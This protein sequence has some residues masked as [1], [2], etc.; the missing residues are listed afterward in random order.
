M[1]REDA[2][3]VGHME[4]VANKIR[5]RVAGITRVDFDADEDLRLALTHLLQTIGEAASRVSKGFRAANPEF[6]WAAIVGMRNKVVHDYMNVDDDVV[7]E[8]AT[9]EME[10]LLRAIARLGARAD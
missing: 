7:W 9:K 5:H 1:Q 2:V 8:T 3:Y 4:E 10:P 6:P